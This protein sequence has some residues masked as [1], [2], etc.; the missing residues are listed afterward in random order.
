MNWPGA[1]EVDDSEGEEE[2]G[3]RKGNTNYKVTN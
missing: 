1:G 2:K 3:R